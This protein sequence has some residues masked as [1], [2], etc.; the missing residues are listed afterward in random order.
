[1]TR[2][3]AAMTLKALSLN[4]RGYERSEHP[5]QT[6]D[7]AAMTLKASSLNNRG[8]ERSEHP[9]MKRAAEPSTLKGSPTVIVALCPRTGHS[10]RVPPTI[11]VFRRS[12]GHCG[13]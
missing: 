1:M 11:L 7:R 10:F 3:A 2:A 4:N 9:R 5:R 12:F 8:Y 13:Y 6:I